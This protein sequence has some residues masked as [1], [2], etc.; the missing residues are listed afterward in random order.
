MV[1]GA[2]VGQEPPAAESAAA[3]RLTFVVN[4]RPVS[5]QA[6]PARP[7][8][9]F[10][11]DELDLTGAKLACDR[12]AE[13]WACAVLVDGRVVA[14]C[15]TPL[16][17][18]AGKRVT[19]I[20]GL[21]SPDALHPLQAAFVDAGAVQCGFCTPGMIL[22]AKALLDQKSEPT[23]AEVAHAMRKH[24]CRCT[25]YV[26][27]VDAVLLGA[28][29]LRG[30]EIGGGLAARAVGPAPGPRPAAV[31]GPVSVTTAVGRPVRSRDGVLRATGRHRFGG[32]LRRAGMLHAKIL[33][34]PH[35]HAEILGIDVSAARALP[36]VFAVL[37]AADI[38]GKNSAGFMGEDQPVLCA[39]KVRYVGDP[40]AVVAATSEAVAEQALARIRVE[41]RPLEPLFNPFDALRPGA[42]RIHSGGNLFATR[43]L[44]R[45]NPAQGFR[46]A[47]VIVEQCYTTPYQEHAYLEPEAGL[48]YL[49]EEGRLTIATGTQNPHDD[50]RVVAALLGL[51]LDRVRIV[52]TESGGGFG[53]KVDTSVQGVLGLLVHRLGRPVRLAYTRAESFLA[54]TKR[55]PFYL[56]YRMGATA[57]GRL[58]ALEAEIV[59][60]KGAYAST[61]WSVIF[62]GVIH[63]T[64]PYEI[65]HVRVHCRGVYTNQS[66]GG[67]LMGFGATQVAF[68]VESQLDLLAER[69]GLDPLDFRLRNAFR[70]G[71]TTATG[72]RLEGGVHIRECLEAVRP[73]YIRA[74]VEARHARSLASQG[75]LRRGV[76]LACGWFG[77]GVSGFR[78]PGRRADAAAE[79]TPEGRVRIYTGC[80][81][82][83]QGSNTALAQIAA[84]AFGLPY[85]AVE[86]VT[87][88]TAQVPD[89]GATVASRGTYFSGHAVL[90][91]CER[92][93]ERLASRAGRLLEED[94][95]QVICEAGAFRSRLDPG[96]RVPLR[97]LAAICR[98]EGIG[99]RAEGS[100]TS[101]VT[102]LD[103]ETSQGIPYETYNYDTQLAEVEVNTETGDIRVLRLTAAF[104]AGRTIHP[105]KIAGQYEGGM[106]FGLGYALREGFEPGRTF[107]FTDYRLTRMDQMPEIVLI[108]LDRPDPA[109]P[110]GAKGVGNLPA[111]AT[112]P[113]IAAAVRHATG[114]HLTAVPFTPDSLRRA[115]VQI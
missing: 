95:G 83:G 73:H 115:L 53:G 61:G 77:I 55:H 84:E 94:P 79:L 37:T 105:V 76:G 65:P 42:P 22:A 102:D 24:L 107:S 1:R 33:R 50:Q 28:A 36:G 67:A 16:A 30:E 11:R 110:F 48:A 46:E 43:G 49:D 104:D 108:N 78:H 72:Q 34:S 17:Q 93:R 66:I 2:S 7:L 114:V 71:S 45:G 31:E 5:V 74:L 12:R 111:N 10:L 92:L 100:L 85:E 25:G 96:Q 39:D 80:A 13:C 57:D 29:A 112:A 9:D 18:V 6:H 3:T 21:G 91:A 75:H 88:D 14:A 86:L 87:G 98:A 97:E 68:A 113:A 15:V 106:T 51:P 60:D 109:G 38:P 82:M 90:Q 103:E 47:D 35:P 89:A 81:E 58:T 40:V 101:R 19:T 59:V 54:T 27:I 56:H 62:R 52:N 8:L 44:V 99:L 26:K 64:G 69:L 32:D 70:P 4:D 63:G 20:E 23:R 41:Y